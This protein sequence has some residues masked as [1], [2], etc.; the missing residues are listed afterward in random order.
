VQEFKARGELLAV[1][2]NT[3]LNR[4]F[5]EEPSAIAVDNEGKLLAADGLFVVRFSESGNVIARFRY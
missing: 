2:T 5:S 3:D 1:I 4:I